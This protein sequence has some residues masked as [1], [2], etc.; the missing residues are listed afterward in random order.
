MEKNCFVWQ[1]SFLTLYSFIYSY[2]SFF[3]M[4]RGT[5]CRFT[6]SQWHVN[7]ELK[8]LHCATIWHCAQR[9][10]LALAHSVHT[11][12]FSVLPPLLSIFSYSPPKIHLRN[13]HLPPS[14]IDCRQ[15]FIL[16]LISTSLLTL[17]SA[18]RETSLFN[19]LI[20]GE[21]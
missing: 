18:T 3:N 4:H 15:S 1:F 8:N 21:H 10:D 7:A 12:L 14:D 20:A 6:D 2:L 5:E 9:A 11:V 17:Q 13:I 19:L 16:L